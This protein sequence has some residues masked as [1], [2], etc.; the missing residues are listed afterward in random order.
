MAATARGE[1]L[2]NAYQAAAAALGER[3]AALLAVAWDRVTDDTD[4]TFARWLATVVPSVLGAQAR[5]VA[6]TDAYLAA[7]LT[8][9]GSAVSAIGLDP[10]RHAGASLRGV[11]IE[12]VYARPLA[13]ARI[14]AEKEGSGLRTAL[15]AERARVVATAATDVQLAA[16]SARLGWAERVPR[17]RGWRRALGSGRHCALCTANVGAVYPR[18]MLMPV[19]QHCKCVTEP[20]L[21]GEGRQR[22]PPTAPAN[23]SPG[24]REAADAGEKVTRIEE[25]GELGPVLVAVGHE[26][27]RDG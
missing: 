13:E 9:E 17:V 3:L 23:D 2:T 15:A 26:F 18:E 8:A 14:L 24:L 10:D 20:V 16:R 5:A 1:R 4:E 6:I 12:A 22:P 21:L 19:H 11:P 25:H 27:S 7:Y